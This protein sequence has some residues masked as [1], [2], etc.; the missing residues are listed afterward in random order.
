[1]NGGAD[2][3]GR[4]GA[5][6]Y[7]G[8][9]DLP[10]PQARAVQTLHTAHGLATLGWRVVVAV[11]RAPR[12]RLS[13][14]LAE[15]GLAPHPNLKILALPTL[16]LPHLPL[17]AYVHPRL[18]VWNWSYGLAAILACRLLPPGW[19][20]GL[21]L[22][23]D[24]RLAWLFLSARAW[25]GA[26]VVYEVHE[27]FSTRAR[28]P[29]APGGRRPPTRTPRVRGL[30]QAVFGRALG[31]VVL[32]GACRAL[33]LEEYG[34]APERVVVAPDAVARVPER[35]PARPT[36]SRTVVYA[37]QLYPWKGVGTLVRALPLLPDVRLKIVGGLADD[38][39]H[40]AALRVLARELGVER[41]ID[42]V[43]FLPHARVAAVI[44]S[45]AAAVVPLPDNPMARF[46]TSP[47]KLFEYMAAGVPIVASD[48]PALREVLAD[49]R[50]GLLVPPDDPAAL[51]AALRRLLDDP[52]LA[53]RLRA[54]AF[55]DVAAHTWA[56]RAATVHEAL[57]RWAGHR[58]A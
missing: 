8:G 2:R 16:R 24:P 20:P 6:L 13:Q 41:R 55:A 28:E 5:L 7:L 10:M 9:I 30:E 33:L 43:G 44:A 42:F 19:R 4:S 38:D 25:T 51:A 22:A 17:A 32:T 29:A 34:L 23:R 58:P 36:D 50:N 18:A 21:V 48:L 49:G 31:L 47:L 11:G 54:Q 14:I 12:D 15:Y 53:D 35:L 52:V 26:E 37:G 46:F 3:P 45:G 27:L 1:V 56:A 40:A 39:P 57:E